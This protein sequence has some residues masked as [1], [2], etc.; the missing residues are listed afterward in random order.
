MQKIIILV[1]ILTS[2]IISKGQD[3]SDE[4][5]NSIPFF[6]ATYSFSIPGADLAKRFGVS[7]TISPAFLF[8]TK[9][10]WIVGAGFSYIFGNNVKQDS[11]FHN[12]KT[13][14]DEI[15]DGNGTYAQVYT[16]QRGMYPA[17][18]AGKIF[19]FLSSNHNSGPCI[20]LSAGL[21]Q[22]KIRIDNPLDAAPQLRGDYRKGYDRLTNGLGV[23]EFIGYYYFSD[24]RVLNFYAGVECLQAWTQ[25][26]RDYNIDDMSVDKSKR[27][28]LSTGIK[29]GWILKL[30]GRA[31]KDYF[32]Y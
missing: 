24:T 17:F 7:S 11:L 14:A 4:V 1:L 26:R 3:K 22:H 30:T 29:I 27:F 9:N 5:S 6:Q 21:F 19:N 32:Y 10:N 13:S 20:M 16:Y 15:I 31:K 23:S 18:Y 2:S 25:C 8:K 28:E 12:L